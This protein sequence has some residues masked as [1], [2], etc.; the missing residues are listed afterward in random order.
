MKSTRMKTTLGVLALSTLGL[1]ATSAQ[2]N[3]ERGGYGRAQKQAY[4]QSQTYSQQ[5]NVRQ[6]R[7]MER[8]R[9]GARKGSL[10]RAEFRELM[11]EQQKIRAM[12]QHFRA[13]GLI[14]GREFQRLDRALDIA[15]LKIKAEK[16]DRPPRHAYG[17]SG[18]RFN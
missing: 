16:H 7:Q 3:W 9:A 10:T 13:D 1:I 8:I 18:F 14:D 4:Q 15:D 12:E 17:Q 2:A 5:I 6:D 11:R